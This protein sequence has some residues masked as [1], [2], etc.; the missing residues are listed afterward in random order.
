MNKKSLLLLLLMT[1]TAF[2]YGPPKLDPQ[3]PEYLA[4][5]FHNGPSS[6]E[7]WDRCDSF[8]TNDEMV[9]ITETSCSFFKKLIFNNC[10]TTRITCHVFD[11]YHD[12]DCSKELHKKTNCSKLDS[13]Q[14]SCEHDITFQVE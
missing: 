13:G 1:T 14:E 7:R 9:C 3:S 6:G 5:S 2:A 12:M 11:N 4:R 10:E 8:A